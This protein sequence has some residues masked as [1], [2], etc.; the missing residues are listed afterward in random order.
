MKRLEALFADGNYQII[1]DAEKYFHNAVYIIF[2]MLGFY[3]EVEHVTTDGRI[4]L[5][6]KT[7]DFV[8]I[9]EF[10]INESAEAALQQIEDKQYA[11]PFG[12]DERSIYK[13]GVNFSTET[14]RIDDW[15]IS[16]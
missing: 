2:K 11:K 1:G 15:E 8:Y 3:V 5:L 10:K 16:V 14:R 12:H 4:D 7:K 13:I 9:I 6:V